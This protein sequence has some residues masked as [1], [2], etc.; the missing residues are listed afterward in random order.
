[1][2]HPVSRAL[3]FVTHTHILS[4]HRASCTTSEVLNSVVKLLTYFENMFGSSRQRSVQFRYRRARFYRSARLSRTSQYLPLLHYA[5]QQINCLK[6]SRFKTHL[7]HK[8][9]P[10]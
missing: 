6:N 3:N 1:V 4:G 9:F 2:T 5:S 10:P 8:S 7:F